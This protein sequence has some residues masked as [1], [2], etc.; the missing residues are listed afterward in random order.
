MLS[1]ANGQIIV[2]FMIRRPPRSTR[3]DTL[4]PY[5]TLFRAAD[6]Q[7]NYKRIVRN[8]QDRL[9]QLL[10]D[11]ILGQKAAETGSE[12]DNDRDCSPH[13]D[14]LKHCLLDRKSTR[15]NSSH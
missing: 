15:L 1:L 2:F 11:L 3:T 10:G 4:I 6:Q 12:T 8:L 7:E 5:T 14:S 13:N 9:T